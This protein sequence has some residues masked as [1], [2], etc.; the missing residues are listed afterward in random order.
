MKKNLYKILAF[1]V[2]IA[3]ILT[4]SS[5]KRE[6]G[7]NPESNIS[8]YNIPQDFKDYFYFAPGS[9]WIYENQRNHSI[10]SVYIVSRNSTNTLDPSRKIKQETIF[11]QYYD[12]YYGVLF[13]NYTKICPTCVDDL[14]NFRYSLKLSSKSGF[15]TGGGVFINVQSKGWFK[16]RS[17]FESN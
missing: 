8:I 6:S 10:D 4:I 12:S 3:A 13:E 1:V 17:S 2:L 14:T 11:I 9:Y 15:P 16:N 7:G 5:C